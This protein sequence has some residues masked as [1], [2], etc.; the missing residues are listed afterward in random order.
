MRTAVGMAMVPRGEVG[1][2]FAELGRASGIFDGATYAAVVLVIAYT[3]LFSPFWI[4]FFYRLYGDKPA[5]ADSQ[6]P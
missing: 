6:A 1:L 2:I 5:L 4:K 3:T